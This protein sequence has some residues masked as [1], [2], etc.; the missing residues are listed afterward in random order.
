[1]P[2]IRPRINDNGLGY[3]DVAPPYQICVLDRLIKFMV[4]QESG[5]FW[6]QADVHLFAR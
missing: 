1:M 6:K 4:F 2:L 3:A 5:L